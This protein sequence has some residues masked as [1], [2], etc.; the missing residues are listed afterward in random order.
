MLNDAKRVIRQRLRSIFRLRD[1]DQGQKV[2]VWYHNFGLWGPCLNIPDSMHVPE[3]KINWSVFERTSY[4]KSILRA[5]HTTSGY[6][7]LDQCGVF[8]ATLHNTTLTL[9]SGTEDSYVRADTHVGARIRADS[10]QKFTLR[11]AFSV[12]GP[13]EYV[14][15]SRRLTT[16]THGKNEDSSPPCLNICQVRSITALG[17]VLNDKLTAADHVSFLMASCSSSLY[18]LRVLRDHGIP[19][20]SLQDVYRATVLAKITYCACSWSGLCSANDAASVM[21]TVLTTHLRSVNCLLQ[22][23]SRYLSECFA[24]NCMY[25]NRCCRRR[26]LATAIYDRASTMDN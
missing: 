22:P 23:I 1:G 19:A 24:T 11:T 13:L 18:A 3:C 9:H 4:D 7:R 2:D 21:D 10:C 20:N 26:R 25:S 16:A 6:A 15:M 12:N 17:V 14:E 5:V 8:H